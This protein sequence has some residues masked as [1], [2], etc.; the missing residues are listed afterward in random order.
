MERGTQ[1]IDAAIREAHYVSKDEAS[2]I[3]P[4]RAIF[5]RAKVKILKKKFGQ[6]NRKSHC[7]R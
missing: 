5:P 7:D 2:E 1:G 3:C 4:K 6:R